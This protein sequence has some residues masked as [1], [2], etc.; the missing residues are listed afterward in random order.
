[1]LL[2]DA[3]SKEQVEQVLAG[4]L[5]QEEAE[6]LREDIESELKD[7]I[8][9]ISRRGEVW[10]Y[11]IEWNL[12]DYVEDN[13]A[14]LNDVIRQSPREYDLSIV[15]REVVGRAI[16]D[17]VLSTRRM[18]TFDFGDRVDASGFQHDAPTSITARIHN[19]RYFPDNYR[20][21][22]AEMAEEFWS[23]LASELG[24]RDRE[25]MEA[26]DHLHTDNYGYGEGESVTIGVS[27]TDFAEWC[28]DLISEHI[29][30][31]AEKNPNEVRAMFRSGLREEAPHLARRFLAAR[32]TDE[33]MLDLAVKW[34]SGDQSDVRSEIEDWLDVV[35]AEGEAAEAEEREVVVEIAE[36]D[37]RKLDITTGA[38]WEERP[39]KLIKL[40]PKDL[41][42]EGTSMRHCVGSKGMK[43]IQAVQNGEIEIWSLRS[44]DN[45]PRFTLE[46]DKSFYEP[47]KRSFSQQDLKRLD[48]TPEGLHAAARGEAIK[49]VKGKANRLPG[50]ADA[51]GR[52]GVVKFPEE[53]TLWAWIFDQLD[54]DGKEVEDF[55][56]FRAITDPS[57]A[58]PP[59]PNTGEACVGFDVPYRPL[60]RP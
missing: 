43:Y 30:E 32:P 27:E 55:L 48:T 31:I 50:Y 13:D 1:M 26:T 18:R 15:D 2:E 51:Y 45:K 60:R 52:S 57:A 21:I 8:R 12:P 4:S 7:T 34:F 42:R 23:D 40:E 11:D 28:R 5:G 29:N 36:D 9:N 39:W 56:A 58:K 35:E 10:D 54:V 20:F 49:Q 24:I 17:D 53:V 47:E 3:T 14:F 41:G 33:D 19:D 59:Q 16:R 38:L 44:K 46:V 22:P 37:L 6:E 25:W